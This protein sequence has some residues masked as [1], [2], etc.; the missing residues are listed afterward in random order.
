MGSSVERRTCDHL[1]C[2]CE[3]VRER[4]R[5]TE[6]GEMAEKQI[7]QTPRRRQALLAYG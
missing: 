3:C 1:R 2:A 4:D 7:S 6:I 5:V